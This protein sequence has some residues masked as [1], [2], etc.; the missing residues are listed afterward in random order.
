M[1]NTPDQETEITIDERVAVQVDLELTTRAIKCQTRL[2]PD[3]KTTIVKVSTSVE[4]R[5]RQLLS[6][7]GFKITK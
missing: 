3:S 4:D 2:T 7:L 6:S 5:V 1:T